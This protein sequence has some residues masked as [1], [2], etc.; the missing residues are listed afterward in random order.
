MS[1]SESDNT[2]TDTAPSGTAPSGSTNENNGASSDTGS[3][4]TTESGSG[5]GSGSNNNGIAETSSGQ[6]NTSVGEST[7][8]GDG[9]GESS[10]TESDNKSSGSKGVGGMLATA[11]KIAVDAAANLARGTGDVAKQKAVALKDA[12]KERIAGTVGGQIA[13]SIKSHQASP[14]FTNNSLGL[15]SETGDDVNEE[16]ASFVNKDKDK[17]KDKT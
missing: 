4:E 3:S 5:S 8:N 13:S 16:I 1:A 10:S 2:P 14:S 7:S 15:E 12:A 11:G 6:A 17:D 9:A